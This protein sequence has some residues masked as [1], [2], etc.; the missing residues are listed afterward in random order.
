M[1]IHY[2]QAHSWKAA[3]LEFESRA[4]DFRI[5]AIHLYKSL[6]ISICGFYPEYTISD[7][8]ISW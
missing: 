2:F 3:E 8:V 1:Y 7:Y 6:P 5:C 4:P